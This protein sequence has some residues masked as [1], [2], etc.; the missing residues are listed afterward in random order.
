[1]LRRI[2][3]IDEDIK[4]LKKQRAVLVKKLAAWEAKQAAANK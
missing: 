4:D 1:M 3:I 2:A